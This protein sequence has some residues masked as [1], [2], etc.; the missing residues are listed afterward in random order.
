VSNTIGVIL[1]SHQR[2][3]TLGLQ[4][5]QIAEQTLQPQQV[6]VFHNASMVLPPDYGRV[7]DC[8]RPARGAE[9]KGVIPQ[10]INS[11]KNLGVWAR[12][13]LALELGTDWVAIFDDDTLPGP[14]WLEHCLATERAIGDC[15]LGAR[16]VIFPEGTREPRV[17]I[18]QPSSQAI[19]GPTEVD[20]VGHCW[21]FRREWL[22]YFH[23]EPRLGYDTCG[24]DYHLSYAVQKHLR[25]KTYVPDQTDP[26][27]FGTLWP[28]L[29]ADSVALYKRTGEESN[30]NNAHERY[31]RAG[32]LPMR[33]PAVKPVAGGGAAFSP[34][35]SKFGYVSPTLVDQEAPLAP[36]S[37]AV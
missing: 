1:Q 29:G 22:Q 11:G 4:L 8:F 17:Y 3:H 27:T 24:E 9:Y 30:K 26:E 13:S 19:Q 37:A 10:V 7:Q 15:V 14:K 6:W 32:W 33:H 23:G 20:I 18:G 28:D 36:T 12:F 5:R 2:P 21:F 34:T 35:K 31:L 16:G 25:L